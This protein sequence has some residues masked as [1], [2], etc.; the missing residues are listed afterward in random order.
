MSPSGAALTLEDLRDQLPITQ[1]VAY[2]Q[3]G[4]HSPTPESVLRTVYDE[5][6]RE[7]HL[8]G[9]PA[10]A[11]ERAEKEGTAR[12]ALAR[13]LHVQPDELAM[14]PS[15]S[16]A[17]L[18][19]LHNLRWHEGDEF[20]ITN[21]E[22]VSVVRNSWALRD[23][24]GVNTKVVPAD[25]G[26]AVLLESLEAALTERTKL[27]C[28]SHLASPEGRLLPVAEAAALAHERGVP[29]VVDAA[30]SLGQFPVDVPSLGCDFLV[31]SG[32]KWLL[33]PMG[34]GFV[35]VAADQ[36][37]TFQ[38]ALL[39]DA[40]PW[41]PPGTSAPPPSAARRA[42]GGTHN[43]AMIIGLGRAVENLSAIGLDTIQAH[44][45]RLTKLLRE[46]V[47]VLERVNILTPTEPGR[48]AGITTLTFDG[49]READLRGLVTY[50]HEQHN[51]IVKF[52]WLTAPMD[53]DKLGM[54]ISVAGFNTE[55]EVRGLI[56]ALREG[57]PRFGN[58]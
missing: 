32:H 34:I 15:T 35:W 54:R 11:A 12:A 53:P 13:F 20:V 31:G 58:S 38:P 40:E 18:R 45:N 16:Q 3:T 14:T 30:Q 33:G 39:S 50:I 27:F 29:V 49:Y 8:H 25:Q 47:G 42:E 1:H 52:Q 22:H 43:A 23:Q 57:V 46:Q 4:G 44:V 24:R 48:S 7:A 26:D 21:L 28:I 55:D 56:A 51:T 9:V 19:V 6:T 17:M 2:L 5:M 36:L 10:V 37:P 41:A